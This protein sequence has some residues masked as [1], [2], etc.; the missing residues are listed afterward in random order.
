MITASHNPGKWNGF[1]Y[2]PEYAGSASPE[3]IAVLERFIAQAQKA[4]DTASPKGNS[5][6]ITKVD[7]VGPDGPSYP[8][9]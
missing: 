8:S 5:A 7:S 2:K 3:V 4:G 1:K 9:L 6:S